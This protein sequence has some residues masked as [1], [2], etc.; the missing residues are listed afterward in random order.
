[1]LERIIALSL[2]LIFI[3][4]FVRKFYSTKI[5][6]N[7]LLPF[8]IS[9]LNPA[10]PTI[11]YFWTEQCSQC[12]SSQKPAIIKL[13]NEGHEFNFISLNAI[14]ESEITKQLN[15]RTVPSTIVLNSEKK[16]RYIN[17]GYT[18]DSIL[19]EQLKKL[20]NQF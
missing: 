6:S 7:G 20:N 2:F 17:S 16:I 1:M 18:A 3:Y 8:K 12:N 5:I 14:K 9:N 10:L 19:K 4:F 13:K 11:L 15:I